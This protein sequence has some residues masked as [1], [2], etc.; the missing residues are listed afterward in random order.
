[1]RMAQ[2]SIIMFGIGL[3]LGMILTPSVVEAFGNVSALWQTLY[4]RF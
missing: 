3:V 2:F 4:W 1:M